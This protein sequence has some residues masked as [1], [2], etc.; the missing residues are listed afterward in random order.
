MITLDF[1]QSFYK[2]AAKRGNILAII[3]FPLVI[4]INI[5]NVLSFFWFDFFYGLGVGIGLP[6]LV[7]G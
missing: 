4:L 5:A 1:K 3:S 7:Y 6:M 2:R